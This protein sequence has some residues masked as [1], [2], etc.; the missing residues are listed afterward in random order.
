MRVTMRV[1]SRSYLLDTG[2][3]FALPVHPPA[4]HSMNSV[5]TC[6]RGTSKLDRGDWQGSC[7]FIRISEVRNNDTLSERLVELGDASVCSATF[8]SNSSL[9]CKR[10]CS[11]VIQHEA[12]NRR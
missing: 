10:S 9:T 6:S 4:H 3:E 2:R 1:N 8:R 5:I 12:R 11:S 7:K